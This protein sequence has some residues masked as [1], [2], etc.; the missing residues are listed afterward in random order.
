MIYVAEVGYYDG[1]AKTAYFS[2][3]AFITG[4][5]DT[6]AH[7]AFHPR[8]SMPALLRMDIFDV[9]MTGGSSRVGYGELVLANDDGALD[10]FNTYG[11]DGRSLVIRVADSAATAYPSGWTTLFRGTMEQIEINSDTA[12]IRIRDRQQFATAAIQPNRYGGTNTLPDGVDGS[13]SDLKGKVKPLVFG[14]VFNVSPVCV[15]TS[16]LVYQVHDGAIRYVNAVYD[17]GARLAQAAEYTSQSEMLAT[18]PAAG[19]YRVYA[20]GGMFRLG[21]SPTAQLTADVIDGLGPHERTAGALFRRVLENAGVGTEQISAPDIAVLDAANRATLGLYVRDDVPVSQVVDDIARSVGAWWASDAD[22][23]LRI[24]RLEAPSGSP[25]LSLTGA[26]IVEGSLTRIPMND[27]GLPAYRVTVR[28]VPNW[29]VQT[30]G[31]VGSVSSARRVRLEQPFQDAVATDSAVQTTYLLAPEI[32][33]ETRLSCL[34]AVQTEADRLLA[35]YKVKRDRFEVR[36]HGP[37]ATLGL[38][39]LGAVVNVTYARFGLNAGKL[40]RIIGYQLDPIA[41][42]ASLTLWG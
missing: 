38:I 26:D 39:D 13:A 33:V 7:T 9:G 8:I 4:A 11:L 41:G 36:I 42:T 17:G 15:N 34:T 5:A 22:G 20:A 19:N 18:E 12:R 35:L 29:T 6:P 1:T 37:A 23:V 2:T 14:A 24:K 10:V 27:G 25:V 28:G 21:S 32:T 40:F 30:S 3:G 16:K 31:L